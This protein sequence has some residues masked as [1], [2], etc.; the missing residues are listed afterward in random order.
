MN[1]EYCV[2]IKYMDEDTYSLDQWHSI[3]SKVLG[4]LGDLDANCICYNAFANDVSAHVYQ[5]INYQ[6]FHSLFTIP[7]VSFVI[8]ER[9]DNCG[10]K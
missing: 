8:S 10:H 9:K 4:L 2:Y 6:Q 3:H 7:G 1:G 5:D